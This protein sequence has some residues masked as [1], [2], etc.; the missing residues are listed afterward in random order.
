MFSRK[1][2]FTI[3][4]SNV[5]IIIVSR[6]LGY[7]IR[8]PIAGFDLVVLMENMIIIL[9]VETRSM[10]DIHFGLF[11]GTKQPIK[12][13]ESGEKTVSKE[14]HLESFAIWTCGYSKLVHSRK[15]IKEGCL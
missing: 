4:F 15:K 11:A 9:T 8:S 12:Y 14:G 10:S 5:W 13:G 7:S 3:I 2:L 6:Y 1:D